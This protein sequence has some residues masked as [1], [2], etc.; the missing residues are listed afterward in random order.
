MSEKGR[1]QRHICAI[2]AVAT[3]EVVA[4]SRVPDAVFSEKVLGDGVAILP[5]EGKFVS[6]VAGR[7]ISVAATG[8][9]PRT[10]T[11]LAD[12]SFSSNK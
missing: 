1:N 12:I 4:L 2:H 8:Q 9:S 11:A 10:K 5:R 3:G 6:P 7:V